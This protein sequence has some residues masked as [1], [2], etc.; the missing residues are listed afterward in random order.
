MTTKE[1]IERDLDDLP[2]ELLEQIYQFIKSVRSRNSN[3]KEVRSFKLGGQFDELNIR[4][5]AY[6]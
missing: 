3:K 1:K 4:Q 2:S 5:R 6:E